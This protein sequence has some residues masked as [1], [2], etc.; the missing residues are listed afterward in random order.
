MVYVAVVH[1]NKTEIRD[2]KSLKEISDY[3]KIGVVPANPHYERGMMQGF[4]VINL[5]KNGQKTNYVR[6]TVPN[7]RELYKADPS[8]HLAIRINAALTIQDKYYRLLKH[9]MN[10][11]SPCLDQIM[12]QSSI[13]T[14]R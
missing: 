3:S 7:F 4:P 12:I 11:E 6:L 5:E 9:S 14:D 2:I 10:S 8:V 13:M 1:P